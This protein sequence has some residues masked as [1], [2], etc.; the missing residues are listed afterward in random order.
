M[1]LKA[2]GWWPVL[3]AAAIA[4]GTV[5]LVY[6]VW[7]SPNRNDLATFGS[8]VAAVALVAAGLIARTWEARKHEDSADALELDRLADL[9]GGVVKDQWT[10]AAADRGLL[11]SEPIPVRWRRSPLTVAGPVAAAVGSKRFAPLP[12][13]SPVSRQR[14]R[15]GR[16]SDLHAIYGGLGSGRLVIVG[17][18]GSGKSGAAVLLV[19]AALSHRERT[20]DAERPQVPVPVMLTM[21]GWDPHTQRVQDWIASRLQQTYPLLAGKGGARNAVG[22]LAAGKVA[23]ILDGLDEIPA[24]LRPVA[25]RALSQ[26]ATFRLVVLTRS[27]EM[28]AAVPHGLLD[29]A[30]ALELRDIDAPTAADYLTRIQLQPAPPQ[31]AEMTGR[32]RQ[33]PDSPLA[34]ALGSPLTLTLVRDTY[35]S[36]DDVGD[37]LAVCDAADHVVTSEEIVD[38]LLDRVLPAA[39]ARRPGD[40]PLRYDLQVARNAL[41]RLAARMNQEGSRDLQWWRIREW[42]PAA[43]RTI[44]TGL[45]AGAG[46]AVLA[47]LVIR[48]VTGL[49]AGLLAALLFGL[50]VGLRDRTPPSLTGPRQLCQVFRLSSAPPGLAVGLPAGVVVGVPVGRAAGFPGGLAAGLAFGLV[51]ALAIW[52]SGV[53][54]PRGS[55]SAVPHGPLTSWQSSRAA[56]LLAGFV[57]GLAGGLAVGLAGGLEGGLAV[58][59]AAG[60]VALLVLWRAALFVVGSAAGLAVGLVAGLVV[61][62]VIGAVAGNA[63]GL[64]EGLALGL[65]AGPAFGIVGGL[66]YTRTWSVTLAFMQLAARWGTPAHLMRFLED[67]RDRNV[68]RTVG[69]VYQ[70]RH[71]RLQDRLAE[72]A[73]TATPR[74]GSRLRRGTMH[75]PP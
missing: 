28:V 50:L 75:K 68:L 56:G 30:A 34:R 2:R 72:Q 9:L 17:P 11:Q 48:P 42:V 26:Q 49:Y 27:A 45:T 15:A 14:L 41:S 70:F 71:A 55:D 73:S 10:R 63:I 62:L 43:P 8:Y 32:L 53:F 69:P 6:A 33:A 46:I 25:L 38:H 18:P 60:L 64:T 40:P 39:Y 35:R 13:L 58:G 67:A 52:L 51:M 1:G 61:T 44:A 66:M 7:R 4:V 65:T 16:I 19:L 47:A 21:H 36:E 31:W 74:L 29:D 37:L 59:L 57:G 5:W 23:V 22:L 3:A 54:S 12:G 24:L 20:A